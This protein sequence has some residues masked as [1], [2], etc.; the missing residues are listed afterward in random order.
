[1]QQDHRDFPLMALKR[2]PLSTTGSEGNEMKHVLFGVLV[3]AAVNTVSAG[4][5]Q[6]CETYA[7]YSAPP[8]VKARAKACRV[9][10]EKARLGT[11]FCYIEHM[12]GIQYKEKDKDLDFDS[13]PF[14]GKIKPASD[15]FFVELKVNDSAEFC[16]Q[17]LAKGDDSLCDPLSAAP[18]T[19]KTESSDVSSSGKSFDSY[20][21][22][23]FGGTFWL[24][25]NRRFRSFQS[26]GN[27]YI[28]EGKCEKIK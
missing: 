5:A 28:S 26:V 15:K 10:K 19:M 2:S 18:Y 27:S 21:F 17:N 7:A 22:N 3:A 12:V 4:Y 6:E 8:E 25:G 9:E 11:Y 23:S 14:T 16:R 1:M 20:Q 24:F 13:P